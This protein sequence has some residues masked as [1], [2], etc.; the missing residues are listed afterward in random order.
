VT[1]PEVEATAARRDEARAAGYRVSGEV[2]TLRRAIE[3][4]TWDYERACAGV[5]LGEDGAAARVEA[6]EARLADLDQNLRRGEAALRC[7]R[8]IE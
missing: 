7:L 5:A 6:A 4:V 8:G 1:S 3:E 2:G